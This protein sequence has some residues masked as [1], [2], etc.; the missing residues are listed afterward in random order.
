[1]TLKDLE[2]KAFIN[3]SAKQ[4]LWESADIK[5]VVLENRLKQIQE[6]IDLNEADWI[7]RAR[8]WLRNKVWGAEEKAKK[9]VKSTLVNP[10]AIIGDEKQALGVVMK[11]LQTAKKQVESF[12]QDALRSSTAINRLQDSVLDAFGKYMNLVDNIP[13]NQRGV[14]E[15]D[16]MQVVSAFYIALMEEKKRIETYLSYLSKEVGSKG[17]EL[18]KSAG[19]MASYKPEKA[20]KASPTSSKSPAGNLVGAKA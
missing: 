8:V 13:M 15:R 14:V 18:G 5:K 16:V 1:M 12:K 3:E 9:A 7:D 20:P 4:A 11:S 6:A 2:L 19:A 17:Y 10:E